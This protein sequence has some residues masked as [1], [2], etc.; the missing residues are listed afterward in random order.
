MTGK[1]KELRKIVPVPMGEA[2]QLLKAN[3]GDVALCAALF[4]AKSI[5]E[6]CELTGCEPKM[7]AAY[8]EAERFDFN[9]TVSSI[10][11]ALYDK[12][13][14]AIE[15]LTKENLRIVLQWLG[16]VESDDFAV[17]LDF[18]QI[19]T[20]VETLSLIPALKDIAS[21]V[22]KAKIAKR[23]IFEGYTDDMP[24]DEFV[25]RHSR[26]DDN[27]DF[28]IAYATIP[29]KVIVLKEEVL[30]HLRNL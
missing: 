6:I 16:V 3:N 26:L 10:R 29:L 30:R 13:Y 12:N 21:L 24:L 18:Q 11:D 27:P 8:Y 4:K 20:V 22:D 9:R 2:M 23:S 17:S 14:K 19:G 28:Q 5:S 7:A 25:R 1:I 15:G